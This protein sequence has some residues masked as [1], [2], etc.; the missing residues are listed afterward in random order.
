MSNIKQA[1]LAHARDDGFRVFPVKPRGKTPAITGWQEA[2][3]TDLDQIEAWWDQ[4]PD[5]NIGLLCGDGLTVVDLDGPA[6]RSW[7][8]EVKE[9]PARG[10][11]TKLVRTGSGGFHL[12]FTDGGD[13]LPQSAGAIAPGVDVRSGGKG[14]VVGA[15][16][17]HP[18]GEPYEAVNGA[19][20][21]RVPAWLYEA[22]AEGQS[23]KADAPRFD[24]DGMIPDGERNATMTSIAG[25]MRRSGLGPDEILAALLATNEARCETPL[26]EEELRTIAG[27]V[28]RYAPERDVVSVPDAA[29]EFEPDPELPP[30]LEAQE[31]IYTEGVELSDE[32][33]C[34]YLVPRLGHRIR[35]L[36]EAKGFWMIW[37]GH[38][39]ARS[40]GPE[41]ENMIRDELTRLASILQAKGRADE[42]DGK[43]FIA[44]ATR[45]QT[46][47]RVSGI[48]NLLRA[49]LAVN[50][51]DF[52]ADPLLVNTPSGPI[53]LRT[54][55]R[56]APDP[57]RLLARA[58]SVAPREGDMPVFRA[59]L[60]TLTGG[61]EEMVEYLQLQLGYSLTGE[62]SEK[63]LQFIWGSNSDTGKST[64]VHI[65][66]KLFGNYHDSVDVEAFVDRRTGQ[67]PAD[68]ARL[69]GTR[70]VT[71]TEP[72]AGQKWDDKT[73]KAITGGD[74]ISARFLYG[75]WFTFTP[76]FKLCIIGNHQP[77]LRG[78]DDGMLRRIHIVPFNNKVPRDRQVAKL[79]DKIVESEGPAVL[80]WI[81]EG[82]RKWLGGARP[83]PVPEKV[84]AATLQY[85]EDEDIFSQWV[86][87]QCELGPDFEVTRG[88]LYE[89][90]RIY[91]NAAGHPPGSKK[92][93]KQTF[94]ARYPELE[95]AGKVPYQLKEGGSRGYRGIRLRPGISFAGDVR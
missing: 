32:W 87:E 71:A 5:Y 10:F 30:V 40:G 55:E 27:S 33:A 67:I 79:A 44:A 93:M 35:Y 72:S 9:D 89:A 8:V 74:E 59:F 1:A 18:N 2:A 51:T 52:D 82:A 16:S 80:H 63:T 31:E 12:Y 57:D 7:G 4:N 54:G 39:W 17:V 95:E 68:L 20:P 15:G 85:A 28:S 21:G 11:Q 50:E 64:Y 3:T 60:D 91:A 75:Q 66:S 13:P 61:D 26:S 25:A 56:S 42:D 45:F 47:T 69:P 24:P 65:M 6:G 58:T 81:I 49:R 78:F 14:Y 86:E 41:A 77:E 92:S 88:E 19:A 29:A 43:R 94:D 76:T 34:S 90:W 46:A 48:S 84:N 23:K 73:V 62:M 53:D 70:L 83:I 37:N 38:V 36:W 22:A